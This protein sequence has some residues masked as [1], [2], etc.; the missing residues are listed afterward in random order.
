MRAF[1]VL[2]FAS[3]FCLPAIGRAQ[4]LLPPGPYAAEGNQI[5][6]VT[7]T[8]TVPVRLACVGHQSSSSASAQFLYSTMRQIAAN[9]FN[10]VRETWYDGVSCP[11]ASN[12]ACTWFNQDLIVWYA[13]LAGLKVIFDHHANEGVQGTLGNADCAN[14]QEN[15]LPYDQNGTA[16]VGGIVWNTLQSNGDGCG[17]PGLYSF[18]QSLADQISLANEMHRVD[19]TQAIVIGF[20]L[21][22]EPLIGSEGH[23][24]AGQC[25]LPGHTLNWGN[26]DGSDLRA[27]Y[28]ILGSAV[29]TADPGALVIAQGPINFTSRFLNGQPMP[30]GANGIGDLSTVGAGPLA[31]AGPSGQSAVVYSI[32]EYPTDISGQQPDSGIAADQFRDLAWG[33]LEARNLAPVWIGEMGASL[34]G[35]NCPF[36]TF[37]CAAYTDE[38]HWAIDI[39]GY[40][41]GLSPDPAAP[42]FAAGTMPISTSWWYW[43]YGPGA[44][45][46]GFCANAACTAPNP[47]QHAI[48]GN[49]WFNTAR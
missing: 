46:N 35:S 15:G 5:V 40:V 7:A 3:A 41:N 16:A 14:Q 12:Y 37:L 11:A 29:E 28:Q 44:N 6:A 38:T 43:G 48:V 25:Q 33:Y 26:A 13:Y 19:P 18:A 36:G 34:D 23:C 22:N 10:C 31:I 42:H 27:A 39:T 24:A 8:G 47:S 4:S 2:L 49:L 30:S 45:P 20:D 1:P 32:H 17:N 21:W 9:G